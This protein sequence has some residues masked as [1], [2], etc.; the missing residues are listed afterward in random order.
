M[1]SRFTRMIFMSAK[2]YVLTLSFLMGCAKEAEKKSV[3]KRVYLV[4]ETSSDNGAGQGTS[5]NG[6]C[7]GEEACIYKDTDTG[8]FLIKAESTLRNFEEAVKYCKSL[9][10]GGFASG[11]RLPT[12]AEL[13]DVLFQREIPEILRTSEEI[14]AVGSKGESLVTTWVALGGILGRTV[15]EAKASERH[16][17]QC[18]K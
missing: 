15:S 13:T 10:Y 17:T 6:E 9:S 2:L 4:R 5:G 12:D 1:I 7:D 8:I 11:W 3:D 16:A 14:W 18:V